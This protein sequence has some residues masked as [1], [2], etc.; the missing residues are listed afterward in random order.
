MKIKKITE[1]SILFDNG[2]KITYDHDQDCC[3]YNYADFAQMDDFAKDYDFKEPLQFEK[4]DGAGFRFGDPDFMV[5]V[6]CYSSQNGYY[7]TE[8]DIYLNGNKVLNLFCKED[9]D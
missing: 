8:L 5:F 3:E 6:P 9:F 2:D 1:E 4:V 7:T